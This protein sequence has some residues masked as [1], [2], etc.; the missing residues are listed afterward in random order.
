MSNYEEKNIR[1]FLK[2]VFDSYENVMDLI[3]TT[4]NFEPDFFEEYIV[5]YLMG[6]DK[7]ITTLGELKETNM[8]IYNH[9]VAVYYDAGALISGMS[10]MTLPVYPKHVDGGVFHPKVII[11]YGEVID[12]D[13]LVEEK[14]HLFVSS[15]NLTTTG[16]GRN[17]EAFTCIQVESKTVAKSLLDFLNKLCD[18]EE[19]DDDKKRHESVRNYL[20]KG[21]KEGKFVESEN[22]NAE[23][24]WNYG[25]TGDSLISR[26][27]ELPKGNMNIISPFFDEKGPQELLD[28]IKGKDEIRVIPA[29][30][31][32]YYNIHIS[33]Y[34]S[35][36]NK[37]I[38]F[39]R[40]DGTTGDN[41][42]ERFVHAKIIT[43]GSYVCIGSYNFTSAAMK[44]K[45]AEAAVIYNVGYEPGFG[46]VD[47]EDK[48][49]LP[50]T[51]EI[52]NGDEGNAG[53]DNIFV[54]ATVD[55][56]IN[57]LIIHAERPANAT[58]KY[59]LTI[60]G[61]KNC[62]GWR[63]W[64]ADDENSIEQR[65]DL[66]EES[67]KAILRHKQ[68]SVYRGDRSCFRGLINEI[69]WV[70][71]RPEI[72]CES[73]DEAIAEWFQYSAKKD[74]EYRCDSRFI[75][76]EDAI[77]EQLTGGTD[78]GATDVF[79]NYYLISSALGN[80]N[81]EILENSETVN[82]KQPT[83]R[84]SK[85]YYI[86]KNEVENAE[87]RLY[88]ILFTNPGSMTQILNFVETENRNNEKNQ[89]M[90]YAWLICEYLEKAL[91][92]MPETLAGISGFEKKKNEFSEKLAQ[93]KG[94]IERGLYTEMSKEMS[95]DEAEKYINWIKKELFKSED[96][97]CLI[98]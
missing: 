43:K 95:T 3:F 33:D 53:L 12:D 21:L 7:K 62:P 98:T 75:T 56:G 73:L 32:G 28:E 47:V 48:D 54:T 9:N 37:G 93:I 70:Q 85:S 46:L 35:L 69:N 92:L 24:F 87:R 96:K 51:E 40:L 29:I 42:L 50:D 80:L 25:E 78:N 52:E 60:D 19:K 20:K 38:C 36:K 84:K 67:K 74:G 8:W 31:K 81:H 22:D 30:D 61:M 82:K 77:T 72:G 45:N 71:E 97:Q 76:E 94:N 41:T 18:D 58:G 23:F 91:E 49:F 63:I 59:I 64:E 10:C 14:V 17:K 83:V 86:W 34:M 57:K 68:F 65:V 6:I 90:V 55:W 13:G 88:G 44:Q 4:Y 11:V 26:L 16:Y 15:C 66:D 5:T 79:D 2:E 1:S 89:D 27:S 39:A